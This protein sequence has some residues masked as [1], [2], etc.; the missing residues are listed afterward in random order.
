MLSIY[1]NSQELDLKQGQDFSF[2]FG[3]NDFEDFTRIVGAKSTSI[4]A[5]NTDK[6]CFLLGYSN[7]LNSDTNIPYS[8]IACQ[9][10]FE[11]LEIDANALIVLQSFSLVDGFTFNLLLFRS[12][13]AVNIGDKTLQ[14]LDL[15]ST[16]ASNANQNYTNASLDYVNA[17]FDMQ[18]GE[19]VG[20][21][22]QWWFQVKR[23]WKLKYIFEKIFQ[24]AGYTLNPLPSEL[25]WLDTRYLQGFPEYTSIESQHQT[26]QDE[27]KG[28]LSL[29][30]DFQIDRGSPP[31]GMLYPNL[32]TWN[33]IETQTPANFT[34]TYAIL[35]NIYTYKV[36][37]SIKNTYSRTTPTGTKTNVDSVI[38]IGYATNNADVINTFEI[39]V[40]SAIDNAST[41]E[42]GSTISGAVANGRLYVLIIWNTNNRY[43]GVDAGSYFSIEISSYIPESIYTWLHAKDLPNQIQRNIVKSILLLST[44][45]VKYDNYTNEVTIV[46]LQDILAG[47]AVDWTDKID[48]ENYDIAYTG[49]Y[50]QNNN[51]KFRNTI[52]GQISYQVSN[53][54]LPNIK[55]TS[56]D[57]VRVQNNA[58]DIAVVDTRKQKLKFSEMSF[59]ESTEEEAFSDRQN[60]FHLFSDRDQKKQDAFIGTL[61]GYSGAFIYRVPV[62][63]S[64]V[65]ST[66]PIYVSVNPE[67]VQNIY[68]LNALQ[69]LE[70]FQDN[71]DTIKNYL[72]EK[73]K[74]LSVRGFLTVT[75]IANL[76]DLVF[77]GGDIN[78]LFVL[79]SV[80]NWTDSQ[81]PCEI[82]LLKVQN[83]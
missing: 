10:Y 81:T 78:A 51:I 59:V 40:Q 9:V 73:Y 50:A 49:Q 6:N 39:V 28:L 2:D 75:D 71:A 3:V 20:A 17:F 68:F 11:G 43:V 29:T 37:A 36:K 4:T 60:Q 70:Q 41:S 38:R 7:V 30:N 34:S 65:V 45:T 5:L 61:D 55:E 31:H 44:C 24:D 53:P 56:I 1:I 26:Y 74:K 79:V 46:S 76:P 80:Q 12:N 19:G 69:T 35:S 42:L 83:V 77:I 16:L 66:N 52:E 27:K 48:F 22:F 64:R 23:S 8:A 33:S 14:D 47:G 13:L 58:G 57:F 63:V 21:G 25:D 18:N 32:V 15:G 54:N 67:L 72:A 62:V 82:E